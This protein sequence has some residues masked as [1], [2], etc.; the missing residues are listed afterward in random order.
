[1]RFHLSGKYILQII[2]VGFFAFIIHNGVLYPDIMESRN[3]IAAREM[4][5]DGNWIVPT[6]NGQPRLEKPPLPT[7]IAAVCDMVSPENIQLQRAMSGIAAILTAIFLYLIIIELTRNKR[8]AFFSALIFCTC[9]NIILIGRT[10]S[11][12]IFCHCFMMGA[13]LLLCRGLEGEGKQWGNFIAA[14]VLSGLSFLSKGPIALYATLLPFI[15]ALVLLKRNFFT[16]KTSLARG[17]LFSF[18]NKGLPI[19]VLVIL[20]VA[21]GFCWY[22]YLHIWETAAIN[23]VID[24]ESTAWISHNT[25]AW[26]Y[27]YKFP[28]EAGIWTVMLLFSF[29]ASYW[30]KK[31][32]EAKRSYIF[33]LVWF[34]AT[35]VLLSLF[36]EKKPRYLLP[37]MIP[38]AF[39]MGYVFDSWERIRETES[40]KS[41]GISRADKTIYRINTLIISIISIAVPVALIVFKQDLGIST[42][43]EVIMVL[44]YISLTICLFRLSIHFAPEAFLYVVC[45]LVVVT[46]AFMLPAFA[47][48]DANKERLS[49]SEFNNLQEYKGLQIYYDASSDVP[50]PEVIYAAQRKILPLKTKDPAAVIKAMPFI[51]INHNGAKEHLPEAV[52]KDTDTLLLGCYNDSSRK[53]RPNKKPKIYM[54]NNLTL[55]KAKPAANSIGDTTE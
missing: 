55:I 38:A 16:S 41:N 31:S 32:Q 6:M 46:E 48:F 7:W 24:K 37:A 14:G 35:L 43:F 26:Y 30:K 40:T 18:K 36:P 19:V 39:L 33:P 12:D 2:I 1:M 3:L 11:W 23:S 13:I 52:L 54:M 27:Y 42:H 51:L 49:I 25:R 47:N 50:R 8:L 21:I 34:A 17:G 28:V 4:V 5:N 45:L 29:A 20:S 22:I 44:M 9:I 53:Q 15:I 10:A